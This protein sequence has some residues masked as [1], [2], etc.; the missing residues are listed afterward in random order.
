LTFGLNAK[1]ITP[2]EL[3]RSFKERLAAILDQ[4]S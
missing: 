4:Y 1:I 3:R 2:E